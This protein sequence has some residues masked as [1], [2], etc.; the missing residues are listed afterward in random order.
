MAGIPPI[1]VYLSES[2]SYRFKALAKKYGVSAS[3]LGSLILIKFMQEKPED[4][5]QLLV[6][7]EPFELSE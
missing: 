2:S 4:L 1:K 5:Q 6:T 3:A 7:L